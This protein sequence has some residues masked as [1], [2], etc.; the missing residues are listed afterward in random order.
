MKSENA[1][2]R[3]FIIRMVG[4]VDSGHE[5]RVIEEK[6]QGVEGE[7]PSL[8]RR[9]SIGGEEEKRSGPCAAT[10]D[11]V[12]PGSVNPGALRERAVSGR[13]GSIGRR[14]GGGRSHSI[15]RSVI[16]VAV[17][18]YDNLACRMSYDF[19]G[20]GSVL[21]RRGGLDRAISRLTFRGWA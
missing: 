16:F 2:A 7:G 15:E 5:V 17:I 3:K 13:S 9:G 10:D 4:A 21:H 14:N 6:S 1:V 11:E 8:V 12:H 18:G 20:T 19:R